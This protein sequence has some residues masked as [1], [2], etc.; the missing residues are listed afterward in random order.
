MRNVQDTF[1]TRKRSVISAFS[2]CMT[3]PLKKGRDMEHFST[4]AV[5][6]FHRLKLC[7]SRATTSCCP[8]KKSSL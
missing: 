7:T 4:I 3:V 1:E 8:G 6:H 5:T 2:L